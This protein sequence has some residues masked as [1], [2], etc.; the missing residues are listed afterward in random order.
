[1]KT[2]SITEFGGPLTRRNDGDINSGL[3][4]FDTSWGYDPFSKPGNLT[5]FE[6]PTSI[7]TVVNNTVVAAKERFESGTTQW[8]YAVDTGGTLY[9]FRPNGV[10]TP[11]LDTTSV[12][13]SLN[14][15]S[16]IGLQYGGSMEFF[17]ATEKIYVGGSNHV[18]SVNFNGSGDAIV[19]DQANYTQNVFRPLKKF[20]GKLFFGNDTN[21][22][23]IDSTGT[24][25]SSVVSAHYEDINPGLPRGI[26]VSDIDASS[27]GNYLTIAASGVPNETFNEERPMAASSKGEVFFYNGIDAGISAFNTYPALPAKAIKTHSQKS[28]LFAGDTFG[29]L[30]FDGTKKLFTLPNNRPPRAGAVLSNGN[31]VSW[32]NPE[33]NGSNLVGSLYYYGQLDDDSK[34]GLYRL[35]R[36]SSGLTNGHVRSV[37]LNILVN[38]D[39]SGLD[40]TT[41]SVVAYSYGKH[42]FSTE[43]I[44]S[45]TTRNTVQRFLIT[46]SGTG[47]VVGGVYETQNQLFSKK[48]KLGEVRFYTEPLVADN[49]FSIGLLNSASSVVASNTYTVGTNVTAGEDLVRWTPPVAPTYSLGFRITN[50]GSANWVGTKVEADINEGGS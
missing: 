41:S 7:L 6:Q 18:K 48:I 22:G 4:K 40:S 21:T 19:G 13:G 34:G 45:G 12:I 27:D 49:S 46:P 32:M 35:L 39:F 47:S 33:Y 25:V 5:W 38:N 26:H 24:V 43:E 31:M 23:S 3:A 37:P 8:V 10:G 9:K 20:L 17:G 28:L 2:L 11:N 42:Y 14:T 30:V 16:T 36:Y 15:S 29:G 1:M 50:L 44:A